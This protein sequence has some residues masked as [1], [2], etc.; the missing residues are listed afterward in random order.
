M[1][2]SDPKVRA[3]VVCLASIGSMV[4]AS[5]ALS[6]ARSVAKYFVWPR[7]NLAARY[8]EGSWALITG[9]SNGL[10]KAYSFEL[11][12]AGFNI[13]LMGRDR[14]KTEAVAMEIRTATGVKTKVLIYDLATLETEDSIKELEKLLKT[15]VA[16]LDVSILANNA[17]VLH[18]GRL[19]DKD[20]SDLQTMI[21][22]NV[23]AQTYISLLMLP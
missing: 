3:A 20:I 1:D 16:E 8:G 21:N 2:I 14:P 17:G 7:S 9:A 11:A 12:H 15:N 19:G 10:G 23:N 13:I 22:V 6:T 4:L 5:K 18:F